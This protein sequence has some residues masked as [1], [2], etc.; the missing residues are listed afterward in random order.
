LSGAFVRR[1]SGLVR[2]LNWWDS[3]GIGFGGV[4]LPIA[5]TS[6]YYAIPATLPHAHIVGGLASS[7]SAHTISDGLH[8]ACICDA[9]VGRGLHLSQ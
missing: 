3:F 7:D 6:F 8:A 9:T 5:M 4:V 1:A 2:S